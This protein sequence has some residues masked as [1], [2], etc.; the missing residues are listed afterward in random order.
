MN[1]IRPD[2]DPNILQNGIR[3]FCEVRIRF[4]PPSESATLSTIQRE[5]VSNISQRT[6]N[7]SA[8]NVFFQE[9]DPIFSPIR[10]RNP[11]HNTGREGV[12]YTPKNNA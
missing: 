11:V 1:I 5:R 8:W 3:F 7:K 4:S 6:I 10:I 9:S 12:E 2:P